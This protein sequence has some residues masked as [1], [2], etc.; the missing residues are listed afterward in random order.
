MS[1]QT[2]QNAAYNEQ[3]RKIAEKLAYVRYYK[4]CYLDPESTPDGMIKSSWDRFTDKELYIKQRTIEAEEMVAE[5]KNIHYKGYITGLAAM[6]QFPEDTET[7]I[8]RR[9]QYA[10][11]AACNLGLI[12][13]TKTTDNA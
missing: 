9:T 7:N 5:M 1:T 10:Y 6:E 4:E 13:P 2:D 3:V 11:Q 8:D 12:P